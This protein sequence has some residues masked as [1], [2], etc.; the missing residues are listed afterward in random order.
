MVPFCLRKSEHAAD[1]FQ[2]MWPTTVLLR[3]TA[4][5]YRSSVYVGSS[6][7]PNSSNSNAK[8]KTR[9]FI[10]GTDLPNL[11]LAKVSRYTVYSSAGCS[12][13]VA[14]VICQVI[15]ELSYNRSV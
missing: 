11:M 3:T 13:S 9:Q 12:C 6:L 5:A 8:F 2:G 7:Q 1:I 15:H 14:M 10:L 4:T